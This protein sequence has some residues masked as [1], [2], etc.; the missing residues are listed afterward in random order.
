MEAIRVTV[1]VVEQRVSFDAVFGAVIADCRRKV[2]REEFARRLGAADPTA[3]GSGFVTQQQLAQALGMRDK[4]NLER[5]EQGIFRCPPY[6]TYRIERLLGLK[7]GTISAEAS[8]Q[9]ERL[10]GGRDTPNEEILE[11]LG[12]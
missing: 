7:E 11:S 3:L 1:S 6:V 12:L 8:R 10:G 9:Y 5:I 4:K 2:R